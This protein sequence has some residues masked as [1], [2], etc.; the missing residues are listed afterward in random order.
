VWKVRHYGTSQTLKGLGYARNEVDI[1][2][3]NRVNKHGVQYTLCIHVDDLLITSNS[4]EMIA[5]LT[6]GLRKWYRKITLKHGP[7]INYLGVS[8][9]FT[10]SGEARLTMAGYVQEI[11][12]TSGVSGTARTP[13]TDTLFDADDSEPVSEAVRVWF[14]RVVAQILYLAKRTRWECLPTVLLLAQHRTWRDFAD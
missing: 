9:D 3:Y 1:C 2:V 11:L 6:D 7:N 5:E 4:K 10:H 14:H 13:A 8:L 12:S